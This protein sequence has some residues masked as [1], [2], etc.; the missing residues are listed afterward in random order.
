MYKQLAAL[1]RRTRFKKIRSR[2]LAAMIGL[3]V[4][5]LFI[6]GYIS[7]HIAEST[8]METNMQTNSDHLRTA[9]EVAD[10]VFRNAIN[11]NRS[12]VWNESITESLRMLKDD[13]A[14]DVDAAKVEIIGELQKMINTNFINS[15]FVDSVCVLDLQYRAYCL[16]RSDNAGVYNGADKAQKI[17]ASRWYQEVAVDMGRVSFFA[18][19]VLGERPDTFSTVKLYRDSS[20]IEG[21]V[22]GVLIINIS[23]SIFDSFY[24][25]SKQYGGE[26]I[27]VD[28]S[29]GQLQTVYTPQATEIG[30]L[31][32]GTLNNALAKIDQADFLP[33][34]Y[35]NETTGW[36][37]IYAVKASELL[38]QSRQ[39][40]VV[41]M[42]IAS[43]IAC[44][45]L[46]ISF[47]ISGSITKPLLQVKR[48]M[49]DW[50]KGQ[51]KFS[52]TFEQ[53]E[54]G[55]IGEAFKRMSAENEEL[56]EK[57][58]S[59]E[60]REREA[61]LRALQAQIKPHF[62]YNTLD[63]IYWMATLGKQQE[64]AQMALSLSESF[65]LSLNKGKE[66]IIVNKELEHIGHYLTIQNIRYQERF[67]YIEQVDD[68]VRGMEILKLLLQP[69]VENA[70]YH[71][72]EPKVGKG[73]ISLTGTTEGDYVLFT[74]EDDGVGIED[75][76]VIDQGYG[77]RN[78]RERIEMYY[79]PSSRLQV[80][81]T[82]GAGTKLE[83][84][85][86]MARKGGKHG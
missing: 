24:S 39:I 70:I 37:F 82:P 64:V 38:K 34:N 6:L 10:L 51:R 44:V 13:T 17:E 67:Q 16:G 84:W 33:V 56:N 50:S 8:L 19:D 58:I 74:I 81:S 66:T 12:I 63:S 78:V 22:I 9:S 60:L 72:L 86:Y 41:T 2:F 5:P 30:G 27:V 23:R 53:D 47:V 49:V 59:T 18:N 46:A 77:L 75:L 31:L 36:Q 14:G 42:V 65:K 43:S 25:G 15:R 26:F 7:F 48:M 55:A 4:P 52:N 69:L 21:E 79:G 54:V 40:R 35:R 29:T 57:L 68:N 80:F 73:T 71:G 32:N 61:E 83:L 20:S 85:L 76:A 45:A 62:L 3:S 1:R 28:T 11:L